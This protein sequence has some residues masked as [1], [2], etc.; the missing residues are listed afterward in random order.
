MGDR[1][2]SPDKICLP[3]DTKRFARI[4]DHRQVRGASFDHQL[5]RRVLAVRKFQRQELRA[6]D[7]LNNHRPVSFH[8]FN[9]AAHPAKVII[10]QDTY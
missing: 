7:V 4:T 10:G 2:Q 8:P 5:S 1:L 9:F 3:D 6:H